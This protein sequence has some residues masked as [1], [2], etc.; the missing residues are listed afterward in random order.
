MPKPDDFSNMS[1]IHYRQK[2]LKA[3]NCLGHLI[4]C[5]FAFFLNSFFA[6]WEIIFHILSK[7]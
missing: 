1:L 6:A 2:T 3:G 4:A 5:V 7:K